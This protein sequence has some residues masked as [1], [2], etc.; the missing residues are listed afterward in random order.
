MSQSDARATRRGVGSQRA[1]G[2]G[3]NSSDDHV[4]L[5]KK[6]SAVLRHRIAEN[7]LSDVLRPDG[8]VPLSRLLATPGFRGIGVDQV[9]WVVEQND[10][11]RFSMS[12][13]DGELF[14]RANQGHTASGVDQSQLLER[15]DEGALR[16]IGNGRAVHGTSCAAWATI[17]AS[18]GLSPMQRHHVHLAADLPG[19]SG[20]IS[21]M[22]A[23]SEVHIWV[24]LLAASRAGIP[25]FRSSNGVILTPGLT[26]TRLLPTE[27]FAQVIDAQRSL[28]WRNGSWQPVV[29]AADASASSGGGAQRSGTG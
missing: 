2:V 15:M 5:S 18:G 16:G 10:K 23:T 19:E 17:V 13:E 22:R 6:L 24:D 26:E 27:F 8:Y 29:T 28:E 7:G 12:D 25:F 11:Q 1:R 14:I 3:K 4:R 21:G 9:R 20:V